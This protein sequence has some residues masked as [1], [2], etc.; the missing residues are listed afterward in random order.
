[1]H[2]FRPQFISQTTK[3]QK[4][5]NQKQIRRICANPGETFLAANEREFLGKLL[6][7]IFNPELPIFSEV[8]ISKPKAN[9]PKSYELTRIM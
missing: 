1:M 9:N 5:Q 2:L 8:K 7:A 6:H 3:R 4:K